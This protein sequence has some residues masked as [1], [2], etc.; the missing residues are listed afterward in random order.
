MEAS[1][2]AQQRDHL[3]TAMTILKTAVDDLHIWI[4]RLFELDDDDLQ[5]DM[6]FSVAIGHLSEA[7]RDIGSAIGRLIGATPEGAS[8]D[9]DADCEASC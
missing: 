4:D 5:R 7:Q 6:P 2:I 9:W 8:Y 1:P 3:N